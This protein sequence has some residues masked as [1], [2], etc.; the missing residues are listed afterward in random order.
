MKA[1]VFLDSLMVLSI[2]CWLHHRELFQVKH[3][4]TA[5]PDH[6][7][8]QN[9]LGINLDFQKG[10]RNQSCSWYWVGEVMITPR[11]GQH[12]QEPQR[13]DQRK[14]VQMSLD[15]SIWNKWPNDYHPSIPL[16][17]TLTGWH[18]PQQGSSWG[19]TTESQ[20]ADVLKLSKLFLKF[21]TKACSLVKSLEPIK[22][23]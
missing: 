8:L 18:S 10:R 19:Q 5:V 1:F 16:P 21:S 14:S 23:K 2:F 11:R 6:Q 9:T 4:T 3:G 7:Q 17:K 20:P 15:T 13:G 12:H 22:N